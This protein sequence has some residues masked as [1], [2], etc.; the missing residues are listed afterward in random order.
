MHCGKGARDPAGASRAEPDQGWPELWQLL[1]SVWQP[2]H[3]QFPSLELVVFHHTVKEDLNTKQVLK[4]LL[5]GV[6]PSAD[7]DKI[8]T[9]DRIR[10]ILKHPDKGGS[11]DIAAKSN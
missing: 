2:F 7:K 8:R 6:S 5:S 10:R 3:V 9:A 1:D 4:Q 11:P